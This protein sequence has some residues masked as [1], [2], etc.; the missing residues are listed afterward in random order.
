MNT[1][2]TEEE[3]IGFYEEN[4]VE[5]KLYRKYIYFDISST[6][7]TT[8]TGTDI[9][10]DTNIDKLIRRDAIVWDS[11]SYGEYNLPFF[12]NNKISYLVY[13]PGLKKISIYNTTN[14]L[15]SGRGRVILEYTKI[16]D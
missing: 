3:L 5:K 8:W 9:L 15:L 11:N 16:T 14:S 2:S 1:Y 12:E 7:S 4:N 10:T 13:R 6:A